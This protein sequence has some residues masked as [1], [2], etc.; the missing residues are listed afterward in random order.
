MELRTPNK[1]YHSDHSIV[2]SCQYHVI[3]CPKFRRKV[4]TAAVA[5]RLRALVLEKQEAYGYVVMDMAIQHDHVHLP[6]DVDP[7]MGVNAIVGHI[8]GYTSHALREEYPWLKQRLPTLWTRSKFI[9]SVGALTLDVVQQYIDNQK[10][11]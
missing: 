3:F 1:P 11:V 6:L 8:K 7:R 5:E 9:A 10:G 2:Y 4:L